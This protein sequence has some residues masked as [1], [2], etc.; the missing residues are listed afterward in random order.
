M[1]DTLIRQ[2]IKTLFFKGKI[3]LPSPTFAKKGMKKKH[4]FESIGTIIRW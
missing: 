1:I 3:N 2:I 4:E